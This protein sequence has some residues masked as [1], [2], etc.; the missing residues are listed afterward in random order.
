MYLLVIQRGCT[1]KS[2]DGNTLCNKHLTFGTDL[3]TLDPED[4]AVKINNG[5]QCLCN[6]ND[7]CNAKTMNEIKEKI[8]GI[9]SGYAS[10]VDSLTLLLVS[11]FGLLFTL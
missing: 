3:M 9:S 5:Y 11:T 6:D 7:Y 8:T 2:I 10:V 1:N 4:E